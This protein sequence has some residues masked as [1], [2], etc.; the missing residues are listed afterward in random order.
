MSH[1]PCR[2]TWEAEAVENGQLS[3]ADRASFERH[4]AGCGICARE[5]EGFAALR[6][7]MRHA[8]RPA[9]S[10]LRLRR[11]RGL[12]LLRAHQK[13]TR[14]LG[15]ALRV[16]WLAATVAVVLLLAGG[17]T[18]FQ[19]RRSRP[20]M[21]LQANAA[22][23]FDVVDIDRAQVTSRT[24]GAITRAT[25]ADGIAAFH[26]ER[27]ANG[28]RFLLTLPDAEIEVHGTRFVV[29]VQDSR[30]RSVEV[31][32][33]AVVLRL[34]GESTERLIGTGERWSAAALAPATMQPAAQPPAAAG[35]PLH[36]PSEPVVGASRTPRAHGQARADA[37]PDSFALEADAAPQVVAR[38]RFAD[39]VGAFGA[40]DY[41]AAD[42]LLEAFVRDFP[43]D[44]RC[45][46]A[47]FLR[48][49]C[50]AKMGDPAGAAALARR[51]LQA[52]PSG[53][54]RREAERLAD[55]R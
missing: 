51:Y 7:T 14:G 23:G 1:P 6:E 2:R 38:Q 9:P 35:Q 44:A 48:A 28:R 47:G 42:G 10:A 27:V 15:A 31:T 52:F 13:H 20:A 26:V 18:F 32:E 8:S 22:P 46:D 50:H 33:G 21:G 25:L 53:L 45:E 29:S 36:R 41:A 5:V 12:L 34:L 16:R 24:E 40:G 43:G 54:R 30:T 39:G 37:P 55:P 4:A 3:D 11:M 19:A 49:M 17:E